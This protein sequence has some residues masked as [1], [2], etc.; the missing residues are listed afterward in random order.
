[1]PGLMQVR[2]KRSGRAQLNPGQPGLGSFPFINFL[3][4]ASVTTPGSSLALP[5]YVNANG[6]PQTSMPNEMLVNV[7][8]PPD[9]AGNW[10][11]RWTGSF[12]SAGYGVEIKGI[13]GTWD[14]ESP[15][16]FFV[17][18][19]PSYGIRLKG[20][21]G[22]IE[23]TPPSGNSS[24]GVSFV[25]NK[26]YSSVTNIELYRKDHEALRDRGEIFTPEYLE[27]LHD[28][29]PSELRFLGW[30]DVN[31][32]NRIRYSHMRPA[33]YL[34][35]QSEQWIPA[36]WGTATSYNSGAN[37]YTVTKSGFT[38][39]DG[40]AIHFKVGSGDSNTSSGPTLVVNGSTEKP[41]V[42]KYWQTIGTGGVF[43]DALATAIYDA[44]LDQW[45]YIPAGFNGPSVPLSIQVA[46]C[47][48][49][50]KDCWPLAPHTFDYDSLASWSAEIRDNLLP[51]L[52]ADLALGNENLLPSATLQKAFMEAHG[53]AR[54][55]PQP[56]YDNG[57]H[58]WAL[59]T[60]MLHVA[61]ESV[62]TANGRSRDSLL[63]T[64]EFLIFLPIEYVVHYFFE[65]NMLTLDSAGMWTTGT[66]GASVEATGNG[67]TLTVSSVNSG[68][69]RAGMSVAGTGVPADT[70]I[71]YLG[72]GAG[73]AG[74][75]FT[76]NN[77]TN[78]TGTYTLGAAGS[79]NAI[80]N[81]Y[82]R[83]VA[84]GG[85]GRPCDFMDR[86]SS[87]IYTR[88]PNMANPF[89][90][91]HHLTSD[92]LQTSQ[93][94]TGISKANP[95]VVTKNSHGYSNGDR[96]KLSVSGMTE[97]GT[98]WTT[99]ANK[100]ANTFEIS[101]TVADSDGSTISSNTSGYTTFTSGTMQRVTPGVNT[102]LLDAADDYDSGDA[103]RIASALAWM[104][105]EQRQGERLNTS[106]VSTLGGATT[107]AQHEGGGGLIYWTQ[108]RDRIVSVFDL[109]FIAYEGGFEGGSTSFVAVAKAGLSADYAQKI[110]ALNVGWRASDYARDEMLYQYNLFASVE[111]FTSPAESQD[112]IVYGANIMAG[113]I[114]G[115][116]LTVTD[117]AVQGTVTLYPGRTITGLGISPGTTVMRQLTGT[118]GGVG[119][120]E[121]S[122]SH[123]AT[124]DIARIQV[125][126][127]LIWS[128][129]LGPSSEGGHRL[130]TYEAFKRFSTNY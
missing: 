1:M 26:D 17:S 97:L 76:N 67:L 104:S 108:I 69:V 15:N 73:G 42:S 100:D 24:L 91:D 80:A 107:K 56:T 40:A 78:N 34:T 32:N 114:T 99:V 19:D 57:F 98:C 50:Q 65:G 77:M 22:Y 66:A 128:M 106:G 28:L 124:G 126:A 55:F 62:W 30:D 58:E 47:N 36:L 14:Y 88:G 81:D 83:T 84:N 3:K 21:D 44:R 11:L 18:T 41:L 74:T 2:G 110:N 60:R 86:S 119:T 54:G 129:V 61:A 127:P 89:L 71:Q 52:K 23:F 92:D 68:T 64:G 8:T 37:R 101:N 118:A 48:R 33:G 39:E 82:S 5:A 125:W 121:V 16:D 27:M 25:A 45:S 20:A 130:G 113:S 49:M 29:N 115:T 96:L 70:Y 93:S 109:P 116:T 72:T 75:Y 7:D 87:A 9:Y 53:D 63:N 59:R 85:E 51:T 4:G 35:Y 31:N 103:A 105:N 122:V 112:L 123:A 117:N 90:P 111:G 43:A 46:L 12:G 102:D 6:Y 79:G 13:N 94:I 10:V 95:G 38:L 120:Y